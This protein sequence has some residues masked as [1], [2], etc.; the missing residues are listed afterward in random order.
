MTFFECHLPFSPKKINDYIELTVSRK[1]ST[2]R[3][4]LVVQNKRQWIIQVVGHSILIRQAQRVLHSY[5]N[6][7]KSNYTPFVFITIMIFQAASNFLTF[8][9]IQPEIFLFFRLIS[10][11]KS[12]IFFKLS[13]NN[14]YQ[15]NCKRLLIHTRYISYCLTVKKISVDAIVFERFSNQ[16]LES[17]PRQH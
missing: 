12:L 8:S 16:T 2:S 7:F 15:K 10:A 17:Q 13:L 4:V 6:C 9:T 1:T 11:S 14:P 3:F 5:V